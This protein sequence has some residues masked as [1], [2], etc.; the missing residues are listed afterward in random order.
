MRSR[1]RDMGRRRVERF[2]GAQ[3]GSA[4]RGEGDPSDTAPTAPVKYNLLE[5]ASVYLAA[6]MTGFPTLW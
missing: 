6:G 5:S 1:V 4:I 2:S 3:S